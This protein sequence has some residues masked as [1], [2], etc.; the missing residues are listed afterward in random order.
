MS[1]TKVTADMI[2]SGSI[3]IQDLVE[4]AELILGG[5]QDVTSVTDMVTGD[6]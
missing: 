2:A 1:V 3:D 5:G 6:Y 4:L